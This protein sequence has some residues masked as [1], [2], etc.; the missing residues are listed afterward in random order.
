MEQKKILWVVLSIAFFIMVIFGVAIYLYAPF[1]NKSVMNSTEIANLGNIQGDDLTVDP[2]KW[3]R[4]PD[5][6]PPLETENAPPINI[7]NNITYVNGQQ[8]ETTG[9][10]SENKDDENSLN[11][12]SLTENKEEEKTT[13]PLPENLAKQINQNDEDSF[14]NERKAE[15]KT[16][17]SAKKGTLAPVEKKSP[18]KKNGAKKTT[19]KKDK[20]KKKKNIKT[21][22][23]FKNKTEAE[24][25]LKKVQDIN[26]FEKSYVSQDRKKG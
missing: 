17:V 8:E 1:R 12:G 6:I 10:N 4:D 11:L 21:V 15:V 14:T 19:V 3:T 25:W 22:G 20:P 5:S 7:Q 26:G 13:A 18:P 9:E 2:V 24:Y 23:P 16:G